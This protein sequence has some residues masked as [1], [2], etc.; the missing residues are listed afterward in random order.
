MEDDCR[1]A[2]GYY[3]N[4]PQLKLQTETTNQATF[5][6][7]PIPARQEL[8]PPKVT[9]KRYDPEVL[10][11]SYNSTFT[12]PTPL[13]EGYSSQVDSLSK[14]VHNQPK[15]VPFYSDTSYK[16]SFPKHEVPIS[17]PRSNWKSNLPTSTSPR[18]SNSRG[19]PATRAP[20][21]GSRPPISIATSSCRP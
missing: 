21:W 15:H 2:N 8:P 7:H 13:K 4:K 1:C 6:S 11:T 12:K 3:R 5:K 20:S 17:P 19:S 16:Q 18:M 10:R 9:S 14:H